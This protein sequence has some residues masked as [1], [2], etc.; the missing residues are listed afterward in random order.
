MSGV[1]RENI[2]A[3][4]LLK[5]ISDC[6]R[7][8]RIPVEPIT[9]RYRVRQNAIFFFFFFFFFFSYFLTECIVGTP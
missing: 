9:A 4:T 6:Y 1:A 8:D 2:P 3:S 5:S 7:P